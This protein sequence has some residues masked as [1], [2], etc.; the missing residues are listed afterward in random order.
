MYSVTFQLTI[1]QQN[2]QASISC[3]SYHIAY[4]D[5]QMDMGLDPPSSAKSALEVQHL[6]WRFFE[7]ILHLTRGIVSFRNETANILFCQSHICD[8]IKYP[9]LMRDYTRV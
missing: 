1:M 7:L 6:K 9:L 4:S 8:K 2:F 3:I 5:I